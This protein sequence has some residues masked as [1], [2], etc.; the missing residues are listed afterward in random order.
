MSKSKKRDEAAAEKVADLARQLIGAAR[1][2]VESE[3]QV[4]QTA[5]VAL[6]EA[7]VPDDF[8]VRADL[9]RSYPGR[10]QFV[11]YGGEH[12][13]KSNSPGVFCVGAFPGWGYI[14]RIPISPE[15]AA[16]GADEVAEFARETLDDEAHDLVVGPFDALVCSVA[17]AK[18]DPPCG[19]P[20]IHRV[21]TVEKVIQ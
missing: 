14:H 9:H 7:S 8:H 16:K 13:A 12:E 15:L 1:A 2:A 4:H 17:L 10:Q 19:W 5:L 6:A 21:E 18:G 3:D 20:M 11:P